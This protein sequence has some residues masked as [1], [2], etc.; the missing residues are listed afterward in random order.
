M[1]VEIVP[2]TVDPDDRAS[3]VPESAAD[4]HGTVAFGT[5]VVVAVVR[6]EHHGVVVP[7]LVTGV[8]RVPGYLQ[9]VVVR[10]TKHDERTVLGREP[11]AIVLLHV[12]AS[13]HVNFQL[14]AVVYCQLT[15]QVVAEPEVAMRVVESDFVLRPRTIED[16]VAVNVLLDQQRKAVGCTV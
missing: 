2:G 8:T 16:V 12:A 11:R 6:A 4:G 10:L 3:P 13:L 5:H 7:H 14:V 15:E 1:P 9:P